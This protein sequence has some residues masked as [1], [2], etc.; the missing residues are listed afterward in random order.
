MD[1]IKQC[2]AVKKLEEIISE[3]LITPVFQPIISLQDGSVLG[4]EALSRIKQKGL[5]D[6]VEVMFHC[7]ESCGM[8]WQLE[9]VCRRAILKEIHQQREAFEQ[10]EARLFMNV[11]PKVLHNEM[12]QAGFTKEY[13]GRYNIDT[14]R[15]VF[16]ITERERI[17]NEE[18]FI[19]A[20][21]HYKKQDYR[22]AIDDV[23]SG[24]SGLNRICNLHPNYIKLDI[25]LIRDLH[26]SPT[27]YAMIKGM[28]EF[29]VNSGILLIAE[30][31]ENQKELKMLIEL[32]VQYGQGY[33][34]AR[35]GK[36]LQVCSDLAYQVI[37]EKNDRKN[38]LN[39]FGIKRYYVKNIAA[40]GLTVPPHAKM[41]S[42]LSYMEKNEKANGVC[43]IENDR[44]L[45]VLTR[46]KFLGQM[47]GRYGF[48]LHHNREI[49]ELADKNFLQV[50]GTSS[51][52]NV[53][54]IAM[55]RES[56]RLYDFIVV[57]EEGKYLGIVTVQ[58]ILKKAMEIDVDLA[59]SANPLT[60]LP[61]NIVIEDEISA[62]VENRSHSTIF[63][64]DLD[65]FKAFND[66]YG[67]E[68]GDE[69]I[70]I[71]ADILKKKAGKKHFVGHIGGDDFVL[72]Y[73]GFP[74]FDICGEIKS[75]F[76]EI[77]HKLY[78]KSDLIK[79]CITTCNRHGEIENF[80]LV[81][82][83][84][85]SLSNEQKPFGSYEEVISTLASYKKTAKVKKKCI[86]NVGERVVS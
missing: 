55:E 22:I 79:N 51:I 37:R 85:V 7:A 15:I 82:V 8:I 69:V 66:V 62:C 1:E 6:N 81:S 14:E 52:S 21:N 45:G 40:S 5:F 10:T 60:G 48:A 84:G 43:I 12:F 65:N 32:G 4:Y 30:G 64:F 77:S 44:V 74:D 39:Y 46:E 41:E 57:C 78:C 59:K 26:K 24:Y 27:K 67:F 72:I 76:E 19:D 50:E 36:Q 63:Y 56:D 23:G 31:I 42:I 38:D 58:D 13:T 25:S 34:L 54:K 29:S 53:A 3:N 49:I 75:E 47:G 83:T 18:S 86:S 70:C 33:F 20:I 68:K 9:Q 35:P 2:S 73:R 11:S 28:V 80:P 61:G 16:E 17:E 71:L